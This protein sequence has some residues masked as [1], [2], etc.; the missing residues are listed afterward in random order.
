MAARLEQAEADTAVAFG[1]RAATAGRDVFGEP[2]GGTHAVYGGPGQPFNKIAGL[3]FAPLDESDLARLEARYDAAGGGIRVEQ[4]SL[5]DPAVAVMLT[6]R[7]YA[8]IGYENVL[9]LALTPDV[10]SRF[11]Q[12]RDAA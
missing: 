9:G 3:G 8:T 10:V 6:R 11:A 5:A 7:G 4:S 2:I 12:A 1:R